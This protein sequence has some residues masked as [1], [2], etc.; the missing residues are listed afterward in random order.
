MVN[1]GPAE[2]VFNPDAGAFT[3]DA[4]GRDDNE[5]AVVVHLVGTVTNRP[6]VARVALTGEVECTSPQ[7]TPV[8]LSGIGSSDPD[9]G[10]TLTHYQW[11][12]EQLRLEPGTPDE[13]VPVTWG[14]GIGPTITTEARLGE[15]TWWLHT[16]DTHLGSGRD[17]ATVRVVDTTPPSLSIA[18]PVCLWPPNHTWARF[19]LS[20]L[21]QGVTDACDVAPRV[22]IVNVK[23][24][25]PV[26]AT[27]SGST[28][29]DVVFGPT[30]ACV[31]SERAGPGSG[32]TYVVVVK[33]T[34]ASG[35]STTRPV[36]I[37]VPHAMAVH[38]S[39]LRVAGVDAPDPGC[40]L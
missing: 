28:A 17:R 8:S 5:Q 9:P 21:V 6:P 10:D 27:G 3:L 36:S 4:L 29:P 24:S 34:D 2:V 22:E 12:E 31:R 25:E 35:N 20:D 19:S 32:R 15:H 37:E 11:F 30:T 16:Y 38:P 1:Q 7:T 23:S 13:Y 14:I 40:Q 26:D 18:D 39:C 33:A